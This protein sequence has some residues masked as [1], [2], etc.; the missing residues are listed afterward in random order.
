MHAPI[1]RDHASQKFLCGYK[2]T[3]NT[4]A[5]YAFTSKPDRDSFAHAEAEYT[6]DT[7]MRHIENEYGRGELERLIA[8]YI[9]PTSSGN[10]TA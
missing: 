7:A 9:H 4:E 6:L 1:I 10:V 2:K 3:A 8:R 5:M